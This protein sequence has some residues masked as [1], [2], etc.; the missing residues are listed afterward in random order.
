MVVVM[1]LTVYGTCLIFGES[2][3]GDMIL[4]TLASCF[5]LEVYEIV[6][7]GFTSEI[8]KDVCHPDKNRIDICRVCV[9]DKHTKLSD[10]KL[11][12]SLNFGKLQCI[13]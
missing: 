12:D 7:Q 11:E 1:L 5:I 6:Y 8:G 4:N 2:N 3:A 9:K 10:T 13:L